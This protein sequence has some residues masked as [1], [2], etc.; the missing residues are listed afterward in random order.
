MIEPIP[1]P[2][3][4][5]PSLY[6][7]LPQLVELQRDRPVVEMRMADGTPAWLVSRYADVHTVLTDYR[8]FSREINQASQTPVAELGGLET[9]SLM[10]MDP[11]KHTR[12]RRLVAHAFTPR[13]VERIRPA[14]RAMVDELLSR[15]M[16]M[17]RPVDLVENF[18]T[19]IPIWVISEL[20]GIAVEDRG[21]CKEWSD[22]MVGDWNRDPARTKAA[23]DGFAGLIDSRRSKPGDDLISELI[24]AQEVHGHLTEREMLMV[25]I[26]LLIGGHETTTNQI[27]L[28]LMALM[29]FRDLW[30]RV[31]ANPQ[32]IP[33]TVEE[34]SRYMQIGVTGV[35]LPR[36]A[37][38][39]VKLSG[40]TIP[41][42]GVVLLAFMVANRDPEVF[43]DPHRMD[44][45]RATN[46]HLGFG[47]GI[48]HCIGVHLARMELQESL[49]GIVRWMPEVRMA[50]PE[51]EVKLVEGLVVRQV[52]ALPLTW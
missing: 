28:F 38:Q 20:L 23:V 18:S 15:M 22:I 1:F 50:I 35:M 6:Q 51:S 8:R 42:G 13:R 21:K 47:I 46:P 2:L 25:C 11:P 49:A 17:P 27:N 16:T 19:P 24:V 9:E 30:D 52:Q 33:K 26:G 39:D 12:M 48:H 36:V 3:P 10:G 40:V 41:A 4:E 5:P 44:V 43:T 37:K 7:P 34:L 29:H 32:D 45:D 31:V 14:V